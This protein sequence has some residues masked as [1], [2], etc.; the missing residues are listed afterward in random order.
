MADSKFLGTSFT[1]SEM[2][3]WCT[4]DLQGDR[5]RNI[6]SSGTATAAPESDSLVYGIGTDSSGTNAVT[7]QYH[8]SGEGWVG[9]TTYTD[10]DGNLRVKKEIFVAMSGIATS[11]IGT[12]IPY[13]TNI[14]S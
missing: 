13:P 8:T 7:S 2:P 11:G 5:F 9:V 1:V 14:T 3:I 10:T 12:G 6:N 4:Q